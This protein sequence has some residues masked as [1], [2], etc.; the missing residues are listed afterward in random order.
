MNE[1]KQK[2]LLAEQKAKALFNTVEERGLIIAGK[3]ESQLIEEIVQIARADFGIENYWHKKIV[4]AGINTMQPFNSNPPDRIIQ[5]DDI[6]VLDFG[7]I[8]QGFESDLGRTYVIGTDPVKQKIKKDVETAWHEAKDWYNDQSSLTG[9]EFFNYV[10]DLT[11]RYGYEFGNAIAGHLVGLYPHEQPDDPKDLCF[12]IHPDNHSSILLSDKNGNSRH[13]ILEI[14]FVD[15]VNNIGGFF[16]QL[17]DQ[18]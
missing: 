4:R 1:I 2:M 12:D 14:Q 16:E 6:V 10:I 8:F 18:V 3:Y 17:L 5:D 9:T 15:R 11:K 7:P 13:W